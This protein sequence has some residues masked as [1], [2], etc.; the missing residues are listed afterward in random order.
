MALKELLLGLEGGLDAY[1]NHDTPSTS[2]GFNY[3]QSTSIFDTKTFNQKSFKFGQGT[4]FDRPNGGFSNEPFV[5]NPTID[6]L[7]GNPNAETAINT[8]TDGLIRGG[9]ITHAERLITDGERIG[10][11]L[12]SP[13]GLAFITKQVGLQ[14]TNPKISR[15]GVG[16]SRANQR[17]YN[18]GV[19]TLASVVSAGTGLYIKREGF[20]PTAR[21]GY[22]DDKALFEDGNNN[23]LW[24]LFETHIE[25]QTTTNNRER[26]KFGQFLFNVK[27]STY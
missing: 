8:F 26:G 9:A 6:I 20:L 10:R 3:G 18:L 15:P 23:R 19:N 27:T 16:I 2:G 14:L 25:R 13:K 7:A 21:D 4:A 5:T 11:F 1:P 24:N 17:T 22:I 12:I